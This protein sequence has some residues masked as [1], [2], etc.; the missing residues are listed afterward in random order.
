MEKQED[1][2]SIIQILKCFCKFP[3]YASS[4]TVQAGSQ[5]Q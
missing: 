4:F 2:V 3:A 1:V 5:D